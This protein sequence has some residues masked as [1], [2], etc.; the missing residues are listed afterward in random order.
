MSRRATLLLLCAA[1]LMLAGAPGLARV[2]VVVG[3]APPRSAWPRLRL[4]AGLLEL[5]RCPVCLGARCIRRR[6]LRSRGVGPRSLD[7]AWPRLGGGRWPLAALAAVRLDGATPR[8]RQARKNPP[9]PYRD[10][11][12]VWGLLT[13]R[14]PGQTSWSRALVRRGTDPGSR[15]RG[16]RDARRRHSG[17]GLRWVKV[18]QPIAGA[19]LLPSPAARIEPEKY[20]KL[21]RPTSA[22]W[23][24]ARQPLPCGVE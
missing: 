12:R 22:R 1:V 18:W 17:E 19:K 15:S 24:E 7:Q 9:E 13:H 2:G 5:E 16:A 4:A 14:P 23:T 21:S 11:I 8:T 6:P 10:M 20:P 3:I